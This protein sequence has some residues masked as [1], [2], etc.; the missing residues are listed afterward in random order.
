MTQ[1][2]VAV[3][4]QRDLRV[5]QCR[6]RCFAGADL[7][8]DPAEQFC[9]NV[10]VDL[11]QRS[12]DVARTGGQEGAGDARHAFHVRRVAA[13]GA[14]CG[15][16]H[17][18]SVVQLQARNVGQLQRPRVAGAVASQPQAAVRL[19]IVALGVAGISE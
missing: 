5:A 18:R 2:D 10:V 14:A 3:A 1:T 19:T 11:P 8:M 16:Y 12:D 15:E 9:R 17:Q 6:G 13:N 7:L 4:R